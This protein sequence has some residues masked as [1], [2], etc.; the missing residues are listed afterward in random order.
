M[1]DRRAVLLISHGSRQPH[2]AEFAHSVANA[3]RREGPG[4]AVAVGFLELDRPSPSHALRQ[5]VGSGYDQI[6]VVPLLFSAGHHYRVDLPAALDA[7]RESHR[8]IQVDTAAPLLTETE[9]DL[10]AALDARLSQTLPEGTGLSGIPDGL[11]LLA[12]GSSDPGARAQVRELSQAWGRRHGLPAEVAF[13]D[14]RGRE[15]R[16]AIALLQAGGARQVACGSLFLAAGRLLDAGQ[17]VALDAGAQAVAGP[18]GTTPVLLDLIR[19]RCLAP[20]AAG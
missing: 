19:R 7:V 4:S 6:Q 1:A 15:V 3:L 10:V 13:C 14:L 20:V 11:V 17:R 5:L 16:S 9:T 8:W 12:A 18:L 2:G